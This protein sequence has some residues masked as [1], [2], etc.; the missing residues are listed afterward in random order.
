ML[1]PW[2]DAAASGGRE[3]AA[4]SGGREDA[5]ASGGRED[6]AAS[7]GLDETSNCRYWR[8]VLEL[9]AFVFIRRQGY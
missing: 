6:A 3:D 1:A 4:A 2:P 8:H 5:T 7:G 9:L